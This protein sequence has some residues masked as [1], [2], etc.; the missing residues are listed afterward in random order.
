[1]ALKA[2]GSEKPL[3]SGGPPLLAAVA[4][5][6][7]EF[8]GIAHDLKLVSERAKQENFV[9]AARSFKLPQQR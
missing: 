5:S 1:L 4:D 8:D 7:L 6:K 2:S 3:S 9:F